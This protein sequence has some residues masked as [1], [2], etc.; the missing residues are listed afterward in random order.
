MT[1]P[2]TPEQLLL[3]ADEFCAAHRV[4]VR[5]FAA[6]V[7]AA[8]VAGARIH[9]VAVHADPAATGEALAQTVLRLE[10]LSG[11]N[12]EFSEVC[13]SLYRRLSP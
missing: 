8:S 9:G 4:Q 2:L 6:L 10:P 7:A 12:R 1:P 5:D 3:I 13:R 11:L